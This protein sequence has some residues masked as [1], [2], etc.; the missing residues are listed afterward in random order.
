MKLVSFGPVG[1]ER[2]GV[3]LEF[4]ILDLCAVDPR[5]PSTVRELIARELL[6]DVRTLVDA[7]RPGDPD[8]VAVQDTRLGPPIPD[9]S[10]IV[11]TGLNYADHAAEQK[12]SLPP[13]P[14]LFA[15]ASTALGGHGDPIVIPAI[16]AKVDLEEGLLRTIQKEW[17][18]AGPILVTTG[19]GGVI[20]MDEAVKLPARTFH[21]SP[22]SG[23]VG[24]AG[25]CGALAGY[26]NVIAFETGGTTNNVSMIYKGKPALTR[27]WKIL[28]NVPCWGSMSTFQQASRPRM[29]LY[30]YTNT[31]QA[32]STIRAIIRGW[33]FG[34]SNLSRI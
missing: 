32:Y 31:S 10:K 34:L 9:A 8:V 24:F 2:P 27:E 17:N 25:Y 30:E 3:L 18:Y 19:S 4:G 11:C 16:E 14:L 29:L 20:G 5:L 28:W 21:S 13:A 22:V 33:Q 1:R 12:K 26:D 23:A 7:A 6:P 15:K